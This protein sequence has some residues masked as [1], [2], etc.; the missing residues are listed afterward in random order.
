[1]V[2]RLVLRTRHS[3]LYIQCYQLYALTLCS[4]LLPVMVPASPGLGGGDDV[5]PGGRLAGGGGGGGGGGG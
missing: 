1:M 5:G 4:S 3:L 2:T